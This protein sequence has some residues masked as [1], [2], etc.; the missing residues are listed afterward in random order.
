MV[1]KRLLSVDPSVKDI[2]LF[3]R[4]SGTLCGFPARQMVS[5][6]VPVSLSEHVTEV[7]GRCHIASRPSV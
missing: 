3:D 6:A 1:E 7:N 4:T 2:G 5:C